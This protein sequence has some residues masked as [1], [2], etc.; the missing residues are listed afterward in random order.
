MKV[1]DLKLGDVFSYSGCPG[2]LYM[3]I[4]YHANRAWQ[5]ICLNDFEVKIFPDETEVEQIK[6]SLV[7][8]K[9]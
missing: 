9:E 5:A 1:K 6:G 8:E 2:M 7:F 4:K 3:K